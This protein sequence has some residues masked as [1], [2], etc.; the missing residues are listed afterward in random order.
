[1]QQAIGRSDE[2]AGRVRQA[3]EKVRTQEAAGLYRMLWG[4]S[5]DDLNQGEATKLVSYLS[6]GELDYRVLAFENLRRI[7][8]KTLN[9]RPELPET[10]RRTSEK[11]WQELLDAGQLTVRPPAA[12]PPAEPVDGP[13]DAP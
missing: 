3:L 9:Y 2:T 4:Y 7:A 6:H 1:L 10:R 5:A 12:E 8:G 11:R 13:P